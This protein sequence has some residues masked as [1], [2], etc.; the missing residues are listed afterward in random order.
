M[1]LKET[2]KLSMKKVHNTLQ[3]YKDLLWIPVKWEVWP[4]KI[5]WIWY[6]IDKIFIES[7]DPKKISEYN[8]EVVKIVGYQVLQILWVKINN[9]TFNTLVEEYHVM[10]KVNFRNNYHKLNHQ[11]IW[12][13]HHPTDLVNYLLLSIRVEHHCQREWVLMVCLIKCI[14]VFLSHK[15]FWNR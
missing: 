3:L 15:V 1:F 8:Q 4:N 5:K 6:Q 9:I 12:E 13:E 11:E 14:M 10:D 2:H 7:K